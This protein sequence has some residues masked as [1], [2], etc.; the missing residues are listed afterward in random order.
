ME[1]EQ[2]KKTD[3]VIPQEKT[4]TR[5]EK[6]QRLKTLRTYQGDM[7]EYISKNNA[8][9]A[10][11]AVAEQKKKEKED[12]KEDFQ[13]Y[14]VKN[15]LLV[16]LSISFLVIGLVAILAVYL[17]QTMGNET[18]TP[19]ESSIITF[20]EKEV[21]VP[22]NKQFIVSEFSRLV[23]NWNSPANSVL[24]IQ[25]LDETQSNIKSNIEKIVSFIGPNMPQT[26]IR[27]LTE[28]YMFGIYSFGQN[29]PFIILKTKDYGVSYSGM[30]K[31]EENILNDLGFIFKIPG[32]TSSYVFEDEF[33]KNKD[34]RVVRSSDRKTIFLYTF[35][36]R[37]TILITSTEEV[38]SAL[39][40]KYINSQITR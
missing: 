24:E 7:Q 29:A 34:L 5:N 38:F 28:D 6:Q 18:P 40:D 25:F 4:P 8:S 39:L 15:K 12:Y 22:Q 11:I 19:M 3:P 30:L 10:T 9:I 31:W 27:S 1:N 35:L 32:E 26:M 20:S 33:F 2:I 17:T 23:E 13:K 14:E 21:V 16:T 36:D 37:E